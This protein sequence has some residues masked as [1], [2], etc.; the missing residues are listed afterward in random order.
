M[1][2]WLVHMIRRFIC[3]IATNN[4]GLFYLLAW[5]PLTASKKELDYCHHKV[6]IWVTSRVTERFDI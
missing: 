2:T 3:N 4:V 5:F 1:F 6:N